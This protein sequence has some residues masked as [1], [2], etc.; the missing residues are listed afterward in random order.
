MT[1]LLTKTTVIILVHHKKPITVF[2]IH[3]FWK[4]FHS[5]IQIK[6]FIVFN[7]T[8]NE[9]KIIKN[10]DVKSYF[11]H[12]ETKVLLGPLLFPMYANDF[13]NLNPTPNPHVFLGKIFFLKNTFTDIVV[14]SQIKWPQTLLAS[15][16]NIHVWRVVSDQ[17]WTVF[18]T[19]SNV[20]PLTWLVRKYIGCSL[21]IAF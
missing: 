2:I 3:Y 14:T 17:N 15:G 8:K 10:V 19:H 6:I 9:V 21:R 7:N 16:K 4:G 1:H 12:T 11:I 18:F 20:D 5:I 13:L